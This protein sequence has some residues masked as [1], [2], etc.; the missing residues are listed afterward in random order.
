MSDTALNRVLRQAGGP[1]IVDVLGER[2]SGAD[3]TT[4][5]LE[6]FRR[7]AAQLAPA[8]VLR[9]Y[10]DDRFVA[11]SPVPFRSL[12]RAEDILLSVIPDDFDVLA[13]SPVAPLGTHS[14]IGTVD[15][16]KVI[17]TIRGSE[18]AADPTN[19]LA[20]EAA[21]RRR[22]ALDQDHR[23]TTPVRLAAI[24]RVVRGQRFAD[25]AASAH[26]GLLGLVSAGRDAGNLGFERHHAVAHI[27]L[28][29][30][31]MRR[32]GAPQAQIR[33]SILDP[34]YTSVAE[35]IERAAPEDVDVVPGPSRHGYYTGL[36]FKAYTSRGEEVAD[37]GFV[38]WTQ[39]LLA[40]RKERLLISGVGT[41]RLA[42]TVG[43]R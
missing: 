22:I 1:D 5:L 29:V 38:T 16:N 41:D 6:V 43:C 37:G 11:P 33:L 36:C 9:R 30:D 32:V 4:L 17:S 26:F 35:A 20:L 7:R 39:D 42:L 40:N 31:A 3:L 19:G 10:L 34:R 15:Q 28:I 8:D 2:L 27:N 18:V 13:L 23:S 24:Q 25:P 21:R 12:R 14:A